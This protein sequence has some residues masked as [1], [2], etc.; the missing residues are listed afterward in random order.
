[1]P[2][3]T[4]LTPE[5]RQ[6]LRDLTQ[7]IR[8]ARNKPREARRALVEQLIAAGVPRKEIADA[9][10]LTRQRLSKIKDGNAKP[11]KSEAA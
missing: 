6:A 4:H 9:C 10:G 8:D 1:M 7:E 3:A 11:R 5:Q 2:S